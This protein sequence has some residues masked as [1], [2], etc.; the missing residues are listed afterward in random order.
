[1][2]N[3]LYWTA[4]WLIAFTALAQV[5]Y[6]LPIVP[7]PTAPSLTTQDSQKGQTIDEPLCFMRTSGGNFVDLERLC[8]REDT[9]LRNRQ[10]ADD[11]S[12]NPNPV[13]FGTGRSYAEDSE[14]SQ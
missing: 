13:R 1:M 10:R 14:D 4:L 7:V 5:A 2:L 9:N 6:S 3:R 11:Q 12:S 8:S